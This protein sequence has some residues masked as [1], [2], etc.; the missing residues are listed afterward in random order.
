MREG[1]RHLLSIAQL[2]IFPATTRLAMLIPS[3]AKSA[4][5][6]GPGPHWGGVG[7]LLTRATDDLSHS[8]AAWLSDRVRL[9]Y[10]GHIDGATA[11]RTLIALG[12]ALF[13][14]RDVPAGARRPAHRGNLPMPVEVPAPMRSRDRVQRRTRDSPTTGRSLLQGILFCMNFGRDHRKS[15][16]VT[17]VGGLALAVTRFI[18][19]RAPSG[20]LDR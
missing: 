16:P 6:S 4:S 1:F 10:N 20:A 5:R 14:S 13:D 3:L 2:P 7:P 17:L 15:S 12:R 19:R 8:Y 18:G 9:L 11:A